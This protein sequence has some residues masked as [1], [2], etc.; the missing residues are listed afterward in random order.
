MV[1]TNQSW[2]G[3]KR[4]DVRRE[5]IQLQFLSIALS[6]HISVVKLGKWR[7]VEYTE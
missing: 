4:D 2:N 7:K 3:L 1:V 5:A 6:T